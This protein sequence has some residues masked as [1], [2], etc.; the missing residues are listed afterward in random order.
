M[1]TRVNSVCNSRNEGIQ[2]KLLC[3][4]NK[5]ESTRRLKNNLPLTHLISIQSAALYKG[6]ITFLLL[7]QGQ[8]CSLHSQDSS[9]QS[10]KDVLCRGE[11]FHCVDTQLFYQEGAVSKQ[12]QITAS[13]PV[14]PVMHCLC[15][16]LHRQVRLGPNTQQLP[17]PIFSGQRKQGLQNLNL[18]GFLRLSSLSMGSNSLC[19]EL[20]IWFIRNCPLSDFSEHLLNLGQTS[21]D[22]GEHH[23]EQKLCY[24]SGP[25]ERDL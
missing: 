25:Q 20:C 17:R 24:D 22:S 14:K 2:G 9:S 12:L 4:I 23:S 8:P 6:L 18:K 1:P 13:A 15:Q 10:R 16:I 3:T 11:G 21:P 7:S 19:M 5:N